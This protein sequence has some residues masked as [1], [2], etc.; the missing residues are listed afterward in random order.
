M[1]GSIRVN[2]S[3]TCRLK[4][5]SFRFFSN[6]PVKFS[7]HLTLREAGDSI[8]QAFLNRPER[9]DVHFWFFF[10]KARASTTAQYAAFSEHY[11][12]LKAETKTKQSFL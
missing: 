8:H 3:L 1:E 11:W 9:N 5:K 2:A 12:F 7:L 10:L 6:P 4:A